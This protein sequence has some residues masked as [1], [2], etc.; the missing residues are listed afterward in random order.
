MFHQNIV[1]YMTKGIVHVCLLTMPSYMWLIHII[2][3]FFFY[4]TVSIQPLTSKGNLT[5]TSW[6]S[7][8]QSPHYVH[9]SYHEHTSLMSI[10][11]TVCSYQ[12]ISYLYYR[13]W[14]RRER[15]RL[16][17][18]KLNK[19]LREWQ[20]SELGECALR[21]LEQQWHI[22]SSQQHVKINWEA[23]RNAAQRKFNT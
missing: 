1:N 13:H 11:L 9:S 7:I 15:W 16:N 3:L 6:Y 2:T 4:L 14:P 21:G 20:I 12:A 10:Y 8:P 17:L 5:F 18:S 23:T 22:L 19:C